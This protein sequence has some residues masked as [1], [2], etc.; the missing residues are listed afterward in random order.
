MAS[1][2]AAIDAGA[3]AEPLMDAQYRGPA[4]R[5]QC[6]ERR[7]TVPNQEPILT[8]PALNPESV[9]YSVM[10]NV[11]AF[12]LTSIILSVGEMKR[13]E[14]VTMVGAAA[15]A[16]PL[17][18][19]AQQADRRRI[20]VLVASASD[21]VDI[22]ERLAG[23][24]QGFAKPG[25]LEDRIHIDVH[26]GASRADQYAVLARELLAL[27]PEVI[28]AHSTPIAVTLH[29]DNPAI[30]IVFVSVSDP[31]GSG[32]VA[33]LAQPGGNATGVLQYEASITG[34]WLAMLKEISPRLTHATILA[35][36]RT[37][38]FDFFLRAAEAS[39]AS[40]AIE[41]VASPVERET[42]IKRG[43]ETCAQMTNCGLLLPPDSTTVLHR[44]LIIALANQHRVPAV[45]P[46]RIFA[47]SG[48]LMSYST[49]QVDLFRTGCI[50][51]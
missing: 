40:L 11:I 9:P 18:S 48:G 16:W 37:T 39:G 26:F 36:P 23:F 27:R 50:L 38:P 1:R 33:S 19:S 7:S 46:F 44:N 3:G 22:Q 30:P 24:R 4:S 47:M 49:D 35:N 29:R 42:E 10:R 15:A 21:D 5:V 20:G 25:W 17:R 34:K 51:R 43:I 32:L 14:F 2:I 12:A 8:P 31:V 28:L 6:W 45:Y 13:R 41:V